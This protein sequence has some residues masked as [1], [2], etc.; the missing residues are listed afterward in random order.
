MICALVLSLLPAVPPDVVTL[1]A[2]L[3]EEGVPV[4]RAVTATFSLWNSPVAGGFVWSDDERAVLVVDGLLTVDIGSARPL[5]PG[6]FAEPRWLE[7]V[8]DDQVLSPRVR[9]GSAPHALEATHAAQCTRLDGLST[10][11]VAALSEVAA[12]PRITVRT[13]PIG[14][15]GGLVLDG[16]CE[17]LPCGN[18]FQACDGSCGTNF[19]SAR[20]CP[21]LETGW[22]F[23][24]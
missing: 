20:T 4:D 16:A 8:I 3:Q 13:R 11:D 19:T 21:T 24:P 23:A 15:G 2:V 12:A 9:V 6:V 10:D 5:P 14:C 22:L 18:Y 1:T 17:T 7:I